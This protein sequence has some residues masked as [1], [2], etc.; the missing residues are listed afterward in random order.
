MAIS[1]SVLF[2]IRNVSDKIC[3]DQNTRYMFN[4]YFL[5]SYHLW[6]NVEDCGRGGHSR[7]DNVAHAHCMLDT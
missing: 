6:D 5:K 4:S 1:H 3:V 7:N 2:E